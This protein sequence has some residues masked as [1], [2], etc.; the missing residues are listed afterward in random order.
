MTFDQQNSEPTSIVP[1]GS[2]WAVH[3]GG[4]LIATLNVQVVS[5]LV[6]QSQLEMCLPAD[7][8]AFTMFQKLGEALEDFAFAV[9]ESVEQELVELGMELRREANHLTLGR[10][11]FGLVWLPATGTFS[12][13]IEAEGKCFA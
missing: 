3:L 6:V 7:P 13:T 10:D 2:H 8:V 5:G 11:F 12:F 1:L 9:A 4:R